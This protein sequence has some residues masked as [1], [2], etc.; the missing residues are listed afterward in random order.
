MSKEGIRRRVVLKVGGVLFRKTP[1]RSQLVRLS[2][3]QLRDIYR[4]LGAFVNFHLRHDNP[5]ARI[6][7]FVMPF[8]Q[9]DSFTCRIDGINN[10]G[11]SGKIFRLLDEAIPGATIRA[12]INHVT[13]SIN[14]EFVAPIARLRSDARDKG[15]AHAMTAARP[16][17]ACAGIWFAVAAVLTLFVVLSVWIMRLA[18]SKTE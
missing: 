6:G 10:I 15:G 8:A 18:S 5:N 16:T 3:R 14:A 13:K 1:M 4:R 12:S 11:F 17:F 9:A 2:E 7:P